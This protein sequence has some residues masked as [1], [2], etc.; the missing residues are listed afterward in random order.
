MLWQTWDFDQLIPYVL[1]DAT[2]LSIIT[3]GITTLY[4]TVRNGTLSIFALDDMLSVT[5]LTVFQHFNTW[6]YAECHHTDCNSCS[7]L[8]MLRDKNEYIMLTVPI[9]FLML[10]VLKLSVVMLTPAIASIMGSAVMRNVVMLIVITIII[11]YNRH[12][13]KL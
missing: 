6:C 3:I 2:T 11:W 1:F 10:S 5:I 13:V 7:V 9:N 12:I 4:P 8:L